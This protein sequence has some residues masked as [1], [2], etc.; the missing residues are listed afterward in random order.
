[1]ERVGVGLRARRLGRLALAEPEESPRVEAD[2][3]LPEARHQLRRPR[4]EEVSRQYG[5]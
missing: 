1:M 5:D 3:F 2:R 4:K